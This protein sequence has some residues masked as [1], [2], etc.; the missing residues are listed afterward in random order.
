MHKI[1]QLRQNNNWNICSLWFIH[2]ESRRRLGSNYCKPELYFQELPSQHI[3]VSHARTVYCT[4]GLRL[5]L[6]LT[7]FAILQFV[8]EIMKI[9]L[10]R[11][12][13]NN[14]YGTVRSQC[15]GLARKKY[16]LKEMRKYLEGK[17]I[18]EYS[19]LFSPFQEG[20]VAFK[21]GNKS[22]LLCMEKDNL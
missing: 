10:Y 17:Q 7:S 1:R 4:Q 21:N 3:F 15:I 19:V 18:H 20:C 22:V 5:Q 2:V 12:T 14:R 13:Y 16:A 9:A 11:S 6:M 8:T